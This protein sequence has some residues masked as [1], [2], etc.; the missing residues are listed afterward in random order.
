[1]GEV[2]MYCSFCGEKNSFRAVYCRC[3]GRQLSNPLEDTQPLPLLDDTAVKKY[4]PVDSA[5][6]ANRPGKKKF[7]KFIC[8]LTALLLLSGLIYVSVTFKTVDEYRTLTVVYG[9]ITVLYFWWQA[10]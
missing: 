7:K 2:V 1:M 8:R 5:I 9:G 3:C 10:R 6:P 4:S